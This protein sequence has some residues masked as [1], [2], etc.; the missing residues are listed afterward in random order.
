MQSGMSRNL[1]LRRPQ[2]WAPRLCNEM[3]LQVLPTIPHYF[4]L[5]SNSAQIPL[6][7]IANFL[8]RQLI[9]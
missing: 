8:A 3:S 9:S 1:F 5:F 7:V 6:K 2:S 4:H